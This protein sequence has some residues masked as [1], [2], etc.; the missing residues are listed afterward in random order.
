M[1][2]ERF[3]YNIDASAL[4]LA[5]LMDGKL[6]LVTNT[7]DMAPEEIVARD[8]SLADIERGFKVL[9]S[10]IA[11]GPI[12]H[13]LPK[14]IRALASVRFFASV[15]KI[16]W[17]VSAGLQAID[18][19]QRKARR[20]VKKPTPKPTLNGRIAV[21]SPDFREHWGLK[22]DAQALRLPWS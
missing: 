6:L 16:V 22:P 9:K 3:C 12:Y 7:Q 17:P 4:R 1:A 5:E 10:E 18:S 20:S 19:R 8:K 14:R 13:C 15:L 11:I 21:V 2:A